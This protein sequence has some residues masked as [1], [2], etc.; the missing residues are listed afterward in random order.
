MNV[1]VTSGCSNAMNM[2][3]ATEFWSH[4]LGH[5]VSVLHSCTAG[6]V[7]VGRMEVVMYTRE[8]EGG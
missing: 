2:A 5:F 7:R 1:H 4:C 3:Q 8:G 6:C